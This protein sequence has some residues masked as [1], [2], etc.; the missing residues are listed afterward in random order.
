M[1]LTRESQCPALIL[2][3]VVFARAMQR[4]RVRPPAVIW[5]VSLSSQYCKSSL[6][7]SWKRRCAS[8][9]LSAISWSLPLM[10]LAVRVL[11]YFSYSAP[12][13]AFADSKAPLMLSRFDARAIVSATPI[14]WSLSALKYESVSELK[15]AS[16][17][18]VV[19]QPKV[20]SAT[21]AKP[22]TRQL[23]KCSI[24]HCRPVWM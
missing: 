18:G 5:A 21:V 8:S 3:T 2:S 9:A 20:N 23:D 6:I 13:T 15:W 12:S 14:P 17:G 7:A 1:T 4:L 11:T 10:P 22:P 16:S 24:V 19:A